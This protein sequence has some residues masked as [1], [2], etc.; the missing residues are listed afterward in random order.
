MK[1]IYIETACNTVKELSRFQ[2]FLYRNFYNY[3]CY[4]DMKNGTNQPTVKTHKFE[5]LKD[6]FVTNLKFRPITDQIGTFT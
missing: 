4:K 2:D 3:E 5:N 6:I 1:G